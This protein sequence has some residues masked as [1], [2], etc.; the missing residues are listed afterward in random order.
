L[1][2]AQGLFIWIFN[3]AWFNSL[4]PDLQ[5]TFKATVKEVCAKIREETKKQE[6]T[7]IEEAK[8]EDGVTFYKLPDADMAFLKKQGDMTHKEFTD[9]I[10]KLNSG[11]RYRPKDYLKEVQ[12]YLGYAV[13]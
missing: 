12:T 7:S 5:T 6:L 11:D 8:K 4:P 1:N 2:Y 9:E 10:N 3:K 13:K